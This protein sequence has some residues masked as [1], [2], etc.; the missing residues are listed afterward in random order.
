MNDDE[1]P[2]DEYE[3]NVS[4]LLRRIRFVIKKLRASPVQYKAYKLQCQ[5]ADIEFLVM[6]LN[7]PTRWNSTFYMLERLLKQKKGFNNWLSTN[8]KVE[9]VK[10]G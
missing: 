2:R 10:L 9:K 8:P 4:T 3:I 6:I 5:V 1:S 7:I